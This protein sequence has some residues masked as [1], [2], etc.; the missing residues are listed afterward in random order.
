MR[1]QDTG[2]HVREDVAP[3][4]RR[5]PKARRPRFP[6]FHVR[7]DVAPLKRV[8]DLR[9]SDYRV[10]FHVRED[11]APLK[12]GLAAVVAKAAWCVSTFV[13]TWLH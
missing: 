1:A 11:V 7:E 13:R 4:K 12:P 9:V 8:C 3:L 10:R 6:C 5:S 2:F